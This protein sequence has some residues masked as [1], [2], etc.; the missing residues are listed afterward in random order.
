MNPIPDW[1]DNLSED[2]GTLSAAL[3][4]KK[5]FVAANTALSYAK[6]GY[7]AMALPLLAYAGPFDVPTIKPLPILNDHQIVATSTSTPSPFHEP[8]GVSIYGGSSKAI[9][10]APASVVITPSII[11]F[12][13][14]NE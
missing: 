6:A 9:N 13:K 4:N 8:S 10:V 1:F 14:I 5:K 11:A 2:A 7:A 3:K 12:S